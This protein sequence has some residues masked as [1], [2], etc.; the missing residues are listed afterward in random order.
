MNVQEINKALVRF[1]KAGKR[2][3][4]EKVNVVYLPLAEKMMEATKDNDNPWP[5]GSCGK[6]AV[7]NSQDLQD[8]FV[9]LSKSDKDT[10]IRECKF[11]IQ[12]YESIQDYVAKNGWRTIS[13]MQRFEKKLFSPE[14]EPAKDTAKDSGEDTAPTVK[15]VAYFADKLASLIAE[16]KVEGISIKDIIGHAK[17]MAN[18]A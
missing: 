15:D 8:I 17:T 12:N 5:A 2:H 9:N 16:A 14:T 11:V 6:T 4:E 10:I 7:N 18:A 3:A 1:T 13:Y